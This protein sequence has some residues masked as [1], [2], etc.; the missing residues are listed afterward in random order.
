M[1][2]AALFLGLLTFVLHEHKNRYEIFFLVPLVLSALVVTKSNMIIPS[3]VIAAYYYLDLFVK[4]FKEKRFSLFGVVTSLATYTLLPLVATI[5]FMATWMVSLYHSS[6]T[7]LYPLL[8]RGYHGMTYGTFLSHYFSFDAYSWV[9]LVFELFGSLNLLVPFLM[10]SVTVLLT[11]FTSKRSVIA[12]LASVFLGYGAL[13]YATGGYSLYYYS[14]SFAFSALIFSL[15]SVSYNYNRDKVAIVS[16]VIVAS[17]FGFHLEK[18]QDIFQQIKNGISYD[19][20]I[21]IG[22]LNAD[23]VSDEELTRYKNLQ[24]SIPEKETIFAVLDN[25]F[26]LDF[27]K[28]TIYIADSPGAVSLPPGMPMFKGESDLEK[29]FLEKNITYIACSCGEKA[30]YSKDHV[31]GML[32]PHVNPWLKTETMNSLD[33]RDNFQKLALQKKVVYD[34]GANIVLDLSLPA[35]SK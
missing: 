34:D 9:R 26:L 15:I 13:I 8:G 19:G 4:D 35:H 12:I 7:M 14:F 30:A 24:K 23:P 10:L 28:N 20:G 29:Y 11:S 31:S 27:T 3:G 25:N 17:L 6:G 33:F 22:L 21:K 32:K 5:A 2:S 1:I 18:G 16:W